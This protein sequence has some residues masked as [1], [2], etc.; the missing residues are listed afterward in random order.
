MSEQLRLSAK[1][2]G[3]PEMNGLDDYAKRMSDDLTTVVPALVWFDVAKVT[4]TADEEGRITRVATARIRKVE[5]IGESPETKRK[6][7]ELY[8][9]LQDLR[10][11]QPSIDFDDLIGSGKVEIRHVDDEVEDGADDE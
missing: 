5:P 11:G 3:N 10:L 6:T 7:A 1:L 8:T 4:E 9:E 2:P